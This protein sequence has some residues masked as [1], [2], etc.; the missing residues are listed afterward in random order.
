MGKAISVKVPTAKVIKA[1]EDALVVREQRFA[2]NEKSEVE[3]QKAYAKYKADMMKLVKSSKAKI[4]DATHFSHYSNRNNP[5]QEVTVSI[6]V[7]KALLPVEPQR[8]ECYQEWEYKRDVEEIGNALRLL[9]MTD[10]QYVNAST[11]AK[12]S[13]YL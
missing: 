7:P 4:T 2:N 10:D 13:Q 11:M 1:L 8:S 9:R 3:Y 12:V 5:E 6:T